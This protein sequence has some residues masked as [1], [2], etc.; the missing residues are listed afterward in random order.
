MSGRA[1]PEKYRLAS[2]RRELSALITPIRFLYCPVPR[3]GLAVLVKSDEM[4]TKTVAQPAAKNANALGVAQKLADERRALVESL[5]A[6]LLEAAENGEDRPPW[7]AYQLAGAAG[8]SEKDLLQLEWPRV[9]RV[10]RNRRAAGTVAARSEA[11]GR[12]ASDEKALAAEEAEWAATV[13]AR[14]AARR[15]VDSREAAVAALRD[16]KLLP[17]FVR[18]EIDRH[19]RLHNE[20]HQGLHREES[21]LVMLESVGPI[22]AAATGKPLGTP[23]ADGLRMMLEGIASDTEHPELQKHARAALHYTEHPA[24]GGRKIRELN[25]DMASIQRLMMLC[26][27]EQMALRP[28]VEKAKA[29]AQAA[30]Q[31]ATE[32]LRNHYVP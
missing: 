23:E 31:V 16:P 6:A 21:R 19:R 2:A 14:E 15:D 18:W 27:E 17:S 4:G 9:K 11:A 29:E 24:F 22:V 1:S 26:Q 5:D 7:V 3:D 8:I 28:R 13:A 10:A 12:A 25:F 20:E 32:E 30:A